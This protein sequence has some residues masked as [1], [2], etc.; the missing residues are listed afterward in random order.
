MI[1][2]NE[3]V[4]SQ[5]NSTDFFCLFLTTGCYLTASLKGRSWHVIGLKCKQEVFFYYFF[6][7]IKSAQLKN[8]AKFSVFKPPQ[9]LEGYCALFRE[10]RFE[11]NTCHNGFKW[12]SLYKQAKQMTFKQNCY[13]KSIFCCIMH[14][15][16]RKCFFFLSEG[17]KFALRADWTL[18]DY[19]FITKWS[20]ACWI[21]RQFLL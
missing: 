10:G 2:G 8:L 4:D 20:E 14:M 3:I 5:S 19:F 11:M 15:C 12:C 13:A 18:L 7:E 16:N 6:I 17:V 1:N 21:K 9:Y